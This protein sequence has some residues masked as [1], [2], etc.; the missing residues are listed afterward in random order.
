MRFFLF[1]AAALA[2]SACGNAQREAAGDCTLSATQEITWPEGDARVTA[3]ASTE[4]ADCESATAVLDLRGADGRSLHRYSI[5]Y[6]DL[7]LSYTREDAQRFLESWADVTQMRSA[8]L[9]AWEAAMSYPGEGVQVLPYRS[10][11]DRATYEAMRTQN[12]ATLCVATQ[13]DMT[14]CFVIDP[15]GA[16]RAVLGYSS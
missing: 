4:G 15:D 16:L 3:V 5:A 14:E 6:S 2:L 10:P 1:A 12:L 7:A 8:A 11:L 9:P 13:V